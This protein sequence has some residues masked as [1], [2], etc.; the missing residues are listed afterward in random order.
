MARYQI[1]KDTLNNFYWILKSDKNGKT[2]CKSSESYETKEGVKKSI[3]W[4]KNNASTD[5]IDDLT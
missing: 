3:I 2:V 5:I 1:K 4:N